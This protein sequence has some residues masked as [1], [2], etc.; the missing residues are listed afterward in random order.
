MAETNAS[1]NSTNNVPLEL[2][3]PLFINYASIILMALASIVAGSFLS[4][5]ANLGKEDKEIMSKHDAMMFPLIG[6]AF[7]FGLYLLFKYF[8]KEYI[9]MLLITYF[10]LVGFVSL[11]KTVTPILKYFTSSAKDKHAIL[12]QFTIP[13]IPFVLEK[14]VLV[15]FGV[16]EI[17]GWIVSLVIVY[18]YITTKGWIYNNIIGLSF[19]VQGIAILSLG[20][21]VIGCVLLGGLFFY[22]VFWVFGTDVMITVAKNFD[23]P[24]KLL[25]PK[26]IFA[27]VFEFSMLGL[28]DIVI[29]GVFIALLLRYDAFRATKKR[30]TTPK[31]KW[32][33]P[34]FVATFIGY[35]LGLV[36]TIAIMH[37]FRHGQPALLYLVPAC[38]GFSFV[39][40]LR[41]GDVKGLLQF[42]E[43]EKEAEKD[44]VKKD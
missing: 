36:V 4:I 7:L 39:T 32:S 11:S 28:G 26:N 19:S 6:S 8:S 10:L 18:L 13:K 15:K 29:P 16:H 14:P 22:D 37:I 41:L 31:G 1:A 44:V 42:N 38:I 35:T 24:I 9:N 27:E 43:E 2:T 23:A 25:F 21:Y 3:L 33:K 20:S 34:Y 5:Y 40:A 12:G 30:S 17:A